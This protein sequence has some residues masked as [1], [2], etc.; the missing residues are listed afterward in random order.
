MPLAAGVHRDDLAGIGPLAGIEDSPYGA[1][2]AERLGVKD[3]GHVVELVRANAVLAGDA[4]ARRHARGHD[5]PAG[6]LHPR[7]HGWI[8]PVEADVGV[9]IAVAGVEHIADGESVVAADSLDLVHD[10]RERR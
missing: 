3:P 2:G 4:S 9:E 6:V 5:L 7:D 8:A 10:V 1:H